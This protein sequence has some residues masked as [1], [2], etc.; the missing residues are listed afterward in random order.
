MTNSNHDQDRELQRDARAW[1]TFSGMNYTAALRLMKH[2]LA[3]GILGERIS[4]RKLISVLR[5]NPVLSEPVWGTD[6]SGNDFETDERV[7]HLGD[8]GLWSAEEHPLRCSAEDD[9]LVV[10]LTAEL[11]R[12]FSPTAEPQDDA[13]SYNLKHTAE[14][15]FAEH[16]GDF[17]Y[18]A[19][20]TAIWAAAA[21]DLPL[22]ATAP[23][24]YTLNANFG[25][26]P[27]QV[28]Y[29]RRTRRNSGS[30]IRAH[31][32]RPPGFLHLA[33][34]L[35]K[36]RETGAIPERWNGADEKAEPLTS[37]FHEW[38]VAQVN[39]AGER[40]VLGSR[41][42]LAHDYRAG[43]ADGDHGVARQP[44][45]LVTLL[46]GLNANEMFLSA[47]RDAIV[48]WARTS[49]ES[50][51]IRTESVDWSRSDHGGW[52]AG[53]GDVERYEYLCPCGEGTILEEHDN[54][55]GFRE[56]DVTIMCSRCRA[57]WKF[58]EGRSVRDWRVE[59][60]LRKPQGEAA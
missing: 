45:E 29:A 32:H 2:P 22:A 35:E 34:A 47:A 54:I 12:A 9:Y 44:E 3:Q 41:E 37:P 23:D 39:P 28:D 58:V 14:E 38:L 49:P 6:G 18:V 43:L 1:S 16:L 4:A 51:G 20:G 8:N 53:G 7:T 10:V 42:S 56:H 31:H 33:S 40:G 27:L 60:I 50:T 17:S 52:G 24:D 46:R 26:E 48:D 21:L 30:T 13:Y 59:P 25:L 36:Y 5:T 11:L 57:E 55:P 15:F 19:N